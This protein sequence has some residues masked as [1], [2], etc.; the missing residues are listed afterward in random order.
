MVGILFK[1]K[2][3]VY[4]NIIIDILLLKKLFIFDKNW[5]EKLVGR[6]T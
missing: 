3:L 6:K 5:L 1:F 2:F 4:S